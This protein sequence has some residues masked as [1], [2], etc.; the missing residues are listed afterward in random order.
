MTRRHLLLGVAAVALLAILGAGAAGYAYFFS[1]ARTAPKPLALGTPA[2]GATPSATASGLS[3]SWSV[4][5]G[6]QAE[7]RV[8]EVFAGTTSPHP[9]VGRTSG[10]SGTLTVEDTGSGLSA[11]NLSF[12]ADLT[13]LASVDQVEGRDVRQRDQLV[14]QALGVSRFPTATFQ[15][16][17]AVELP[18]GFGDGQQVQLTV[19]GRLTIHGVTKDVTVNVGQLQLAGSQVQAAGTIQTTMGTFEIQPPSAPFVTVHQNV[20]IGF[21]LH[22]ARA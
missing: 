14:R 18:A 3:G 22:L 1:G 16:S 15:S 7:W 5:A 4:T 2:P 10:L 13:G 8:S 6:S 12:T 21:L 20:T 17:Q 19:P 9:A 11:G